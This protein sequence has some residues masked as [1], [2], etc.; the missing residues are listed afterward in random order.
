MERIASRQN[1]IV[2][3]LRA[4]ARSPSDDVLLDGAHLLEEALASGVPIEVIAV[5]ELLADGPLR[6]LISRAAEAGARVLAVSESVMEAIS[7]VRRPSGIVAIARR[8]P[9][10]LEAAL[11][12]PPQMVMILADVQDPGNVGA[13]VR[14]AEACGAT[15]VVTTGGSADPFGWKAIRGS[16]GSIFRVRVATGQSLDA[17]IE[18]A[19]A[20]DIRV[21][22]A[23]PSAGTPVCDCDLR[24]AA[25]VLLGGEGPG[26]SA[27]IVERADRTLS[28]PMRPPVESLNVA[29]AAAIILYEA[30]R[31]RD[32]GCG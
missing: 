9:D 31:Q 15:G 27:H 4:L 10:A 25:A 24:S 17:A 18:S 19:H 2:K 11:D 23:V 30:Q 16:M 6:A 13:I 1:A 28:I 7:P 21:Y 12:R 5:K 32:G 29:T 20:N 14:A 26:L 8:R 3:R 22:A